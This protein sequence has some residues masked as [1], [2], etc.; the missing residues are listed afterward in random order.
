MKEIINRA[1]IPSINM[2][3]VSMRRI[4]SLIY[5]KEF[6]DRV[7]SQ[8]YVDEET[9]ES[10]VKRYGVT[11]DII[12]WGDYFQVEMATAMMNHS[13]DEFS[14]AVETVRFDVISSYIIFSTQNDDFIK[15][16]DQQYLTVSTRD[17]EELSEE[18]EEILHLKIL[19][20]Y[21]NDMAIVNNFTDAE[22]DWYGDFTE[23]SAM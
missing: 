3:L 15:W 18:D 22:M 14:K 17:T 1:L 16:I 21:Y 5:I 11:P 7:A 10:L 13:D 2:G 19:R 12:T 4:D 6:V 9:A 23:A 8:H 20:D